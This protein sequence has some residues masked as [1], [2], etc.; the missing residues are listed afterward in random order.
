MG[1]AGSGRCSYGSPPPQA[2]GQNF[3]VNYLNN[4]TYKRVAAVTLA[5]L[6]G[7]QLA[8]CNSEDNPSTIDPPSGVGSPPPPPPPAVTV[9]G[10]AADGYLVGAT[11]CLD[12]DADMFCDASEPTA[13]T[14]AGGAFTLTIPNDVD[15]SAHAI[16]VQVSATTVDEDS[17]RLHSADID[18]TRFTPPRL[19][20]QR[21]SVSLM[22]ALRLP[23][24]GRV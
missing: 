5:L 18:F 1:N 17:E 11:V 8:G 22:R 3:L 14:T 4:R 12:V 7:A 15:A 21:F 19:R 6:A 13:T 2:R 10:K 9:S 16:V 24:N 20:A 23:L